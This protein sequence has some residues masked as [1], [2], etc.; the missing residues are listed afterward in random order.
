MSTVKLGLIG[1]GEWPRQAYLPV[2]KS[3]DAAEVCAVAARSAATQQFAREQFG[4]GVALYGDYHDLLQ[5][6]AVEAVLVALPNTLHAEGTLAA[7]TSGKHVFYEPPLG[8]TAEEIDR[9]L[10][11]MRA[12][13]R[14]VQADFELRYL[15]VID[16]VRQLVASR[17]IG[18]PLMARVRLWADWGYGGGAWSQN[19]EDEGFFPWLSCWYLDVLDCVFE[20]PPLR[21]SVVGGHAMNGRLLDH[22][23]ATLEYRD[24]QVGECEFSLVAVDG[25][26]VRLLALGTK[27][28]LEADLITGR[29]RWRGADGAWQE[30]TRPC[31]EPVHGF[32]GMRESIADF[33]AAVQEGRAA[34]ADAEV[35]ARV[36]Q[37]MLL[38]AQAEAD[39]YGGRTN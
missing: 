26:E 21:A 38:C 37:A 10:G 15:P 36:H 31:S 25:L 33:L 29:C 39:A 32:A 35:A 3:L 34:K 24:G 28:E 19:P 17:A 16:Q 20:T 8:H 18:D 1:L 6:D 2:L 5:D 22:G 4:D 9:A 12:C 14:V 13:D 11:A 7:V 23:W 30:A 27:G